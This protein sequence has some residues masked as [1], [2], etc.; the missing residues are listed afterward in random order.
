[1][2]ITVQREVYTDKS[3]QGEMLIDGQHFCWTLEPRKDQLRGKPY[4]IPAG[5]YTVI[6]QRSAR[7]QMTTPHLLDVPG[8]TEIEIHPGNYSR[9]TEGCTLVGLEK[10]TDFVGQSRDAFDALMGKILTACEITYLG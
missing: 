9:D 6:L 7:F 5:T 3:T 4:C 1:M 10:N 8:F 2:Q